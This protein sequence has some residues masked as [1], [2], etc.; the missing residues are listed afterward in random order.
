MASIFLP[1]LKCFSSS[2]ILITWSCLPVRLS[3]SGPC[4][5]PALGELPRALVHGREPDGARGS[6]WEEAAETRAQTDEEI[7]MLQRRWSSIFIHRILYTDSREIISYSGRNVVD[8]D[9]DLIKW[10]T[11]CPC[12]P[13]FYSLLFLNVLQNYETKSSFFRWYH[14]WNFKYYFY[15]LSLHCF[16]LR[17]GRGTSGT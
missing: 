4:P 7:L 13:S 3:G 9:P 6:E 17:Q 10:K 12:L 5:P 1:F 2:L 11:C 15:S 16:L 14:G 8:P